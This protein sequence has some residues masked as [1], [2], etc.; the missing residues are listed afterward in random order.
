[1]QTLRRFVK[2]EAPGIAA[3][4]TNEQRITMLDMSMR[5]AY[6]NKKQFK[7]EMP[8]NIIPI[9]ANEPEA[10]EL[11]KAA[12]AETVVVDLNLMGR[13]SMKRKGE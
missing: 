8:S 7:I 2:E 5:R 4:L 11:R 1:M 9:R 12:G 13:N 6:E 3:N 10:E